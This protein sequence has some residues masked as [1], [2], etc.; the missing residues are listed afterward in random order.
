M[1][2]DATTY[3]D[4]YYYGS[5]RSH[6]PVSDIYNHYHRQSISS[7]SSVI[8]IDPQIS[9]MMTTSMLGQWT[10]ETAPPVALPPATFDEGSAPY[11]TVSSYNLWPRAFAEADQSPTVTSLPVPLHELD[12][13]EYAA[14]QRE[15]ST[16]PGLIFQSNG[17]TI[18]WD[19][20]D[21]YWQYFHPSFPIVHKP[22]FLPAKPSPLLASA[23]LAIGSYYD[24]RPDAKLYS[25]ALQ[26]SA[27]KLLRR[28][29]N[30]A[31][32]SRIAD[33]QTVLLLEILSKFCARQISAQTSSRFRSLFA[34]L[35]QSQQWL[36]T[37]PLAVHKAQSSKARSPDDLKR[38]HKFWVEH[39]TR[40]RIF[41]ACSVLDAQ[42]VCLFEQRA[43][44]VSHNKMH[45]HDIKGT[46]QLPCDEELWEASTIDEWS[47]KA[48]RHVG[49][50]LNEART[51][52]QNASVGDYSF[53]Q[54]QIINANA[55]AA[56]R[57][58]EEIESPPPSTGALV[59]KTRFNYHVFQMAKHIPIRNL[60]IVAGESWLLDRK[61]EQEA[62]YIQ[63]KHVMREWVN[64]AIPPITKNHIPDILH[65][66]W[67][68]LKVLRMVVDP[69]EGPY[70][71]RSTNMLHED[72]SIYLAIL[73]CWAHG[74][75][76]RTR[77]QTSTPTTS[78]PRT[79]S[80]STSRKRKNDKDNTQPRKRSALI[81]TFS[82]ISPTPALA[83]HPEQPPFIPPSTS[84][85][86]MT[87]P[88]YTNN[89]WITNPYYTTTPPLT[90]P[91]STQTVDSISVL[92]TIPSTTTTTT[93]SSTPLSMLSAPTSIPYSKPTLHRATSS[94]MQDLKI[95]LTQTDV[96]SPLAL[97]TLDPAILAQTTGL[98]E[99]IR[100]NK[101]GKKGIV[102]GLMN[103]AERV[104]KRLSEG[105]G[106]DMF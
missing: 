40:R 29:T 52:Y 85:I 1:P 21:H 43:T 99:T 37:S 57:C 74:Y 28:R 14:I 38:A 105:R 88:T 64:Q 20:L 35:Y 58:S 84:Y 39:E 97:T 11:I 65:A 86:D 13:H 15:L 100:I 67:H 41:H 70:A 48:E 50:D 68:A 56:Q 103:D 5:E 8:G 72:W 66:H 51:S 31:A 89:P 17:N 78:F 23:V 36:S 53:F 60:L 95:Y 32:R 79:I 42:Q 19:C 16:V 77:P 80:P 44:I 2:A 24:T 104:L 75:E 33:L 18:R 69:T 49:Q 63:A 34:S 27:M 61:V 92:S 47:L 81:P 71:F 3:G 90:A 9:P 46:V 7:A 6:S 59:S 87:F 91:Y 10:P 96:P 98:L 26:E 12:G 62:E 101:F 106:G 93:A 4:G 30:I 22:T 82:N 73:V 25:L 76:C 55:S 45:V 83:A 54:H 94:A 102:G